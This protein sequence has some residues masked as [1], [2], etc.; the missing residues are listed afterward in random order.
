MMKEQAKALQEEAQTARYAEQQRAMKALVK[1][2]AE[3][4]LE[5]LQIAETLT[6]VYA[7]TAKE[8]ENIVQEYTEQ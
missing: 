2:L 5:P 6:A 3:K 4:G 1:T 8:A 7:I